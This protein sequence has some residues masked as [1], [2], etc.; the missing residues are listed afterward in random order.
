MFSAA[1]RLL[2]RMTPGLRVTVPSSKVTVPSSPMVAPLSKV[3][4]VLRHPATESQ[5]AIAAEVARQVITDGDVAAVGLCFAPAAEDRDEVEQFVEELQSLEHTR[6]L[7]GI[8]G[9][10]DDIDGARRV[11]DTVATAVFER[12]RQVDAC[13]TALPELGSGWRERP[14]PSGSATRC[15]PC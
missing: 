3:T 12:I 15:G 7:G 13:T 5:M 1:M 10:L 9:P 8:S 6:R 4:V 2:F 14:S 11:Y